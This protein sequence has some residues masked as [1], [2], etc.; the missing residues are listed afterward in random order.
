MGAQDVLSRK[1]GVIVGEDVEKLFKYAQEHNFALP[2]IN[3]T[4]SSTVVGSLEAAKVRLFQ[5]CIGSRIGFAPLSSLFPLDGR[6]R[7]IYESLS[8]CR[9]PA[10]L[11]CSKSRKEEQHISAERA[12][13]TMARQLPLL[14]LLLLRITF[15]RLRRLMAFRSFCTLV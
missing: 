4:S 9:T 12:C 1:T 3:V 11:S 7:L 10:L 5:S 14:A 13:R 6:S 2:A 8:F 15:A